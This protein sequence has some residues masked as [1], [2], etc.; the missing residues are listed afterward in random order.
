[1]AGERPVISVV[2]PARDAAGTLPG[3][4]AALDAQQLDQPF[5]VVVADAGSSDDTAALARRA[6][7]HVV[8]AG[9]VGPG[10]A[11]NAGVARASADL[12]AFTDADCRPAPGWLAAGL[13]ALGHADLVQGAVRPDAG[14][15]LGPFDRTLGVEAETGLYETA[16][17]FVRREAFERAGGFGPG[18]GPRMGAAHMGEDTLLGWRVRRSGTTAFCAG[19]VVEHAVIRRTL[20]GHVAE[21][22]RERYFPEL[23]AQVPELRQTLLAGRLFLSRRGAAFD[24]AA[25]GVLVALARR[26]PFAATATLPYVGAVARRSRPWGRLAASAAMGTV[27]GDAV[28]AWSLVLG[29]VR[30]RTP[31]L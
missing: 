11:R 8:D 9:P 28:G 4:L 1:M 5:E 2:V 16:N 24:V 6:G 13:R 17:L 22:R 15:T 3:S 29:S 26:S 7:A 21:R 19:A 23:V 30:A 18:L 25:V 31:V 12:L 14:A 20:A 27:A 10:E